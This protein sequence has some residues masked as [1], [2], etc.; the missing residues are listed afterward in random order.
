MLPTRKKN[1]FKY[2]DTKRILKQW[3]EI[4]HTNSIQIKSCNIDRR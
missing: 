2:D 4:C 3:K 1:D